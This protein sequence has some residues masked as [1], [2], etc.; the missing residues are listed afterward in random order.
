[1]LRPQVEVAK[2]KLRILREGRNS[3][4]KKAVVQKTFAA[5]SANGRPVLYVTERAVF[6]L[7]EG[8]GIQLIEVQLLGF[9]LSPFRT[10]APAH[11]SHSCELSAL[12]SLRE[13]RCS[14][15]HMSLLT[16]ALQIAPGIDLERD[17]LAHMPF[18]PLLEGVKVMDERCFLP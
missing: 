14:E 3:K 11:A 12:H 8:R 5:S 15:G 10:H 13:D 16:A 4:F 9:Q 17:V 6:R 7:V 2:G 18:R 1:M